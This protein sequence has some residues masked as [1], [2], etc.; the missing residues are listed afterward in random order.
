MSK[1]RFL[2]IAAA[3]LGSHLIGNSVGM[4]G[5][6]AFAAQPDLSCPCAGDA[7]DSVD[8][9]KI[10]RRGDS[11]R[12]KVV[13]S[14]ESEDEGNNTTYTGDISATD[15]LKVKK[16]GRASLMLRGPESES[17]FGAVTGIVGVLHVDGKNS[18]FLE[19][20]P[21]KTAADKPATLDAFKLR[22]R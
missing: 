1:Y 5:H 9:Y 17:I 18:F 6:R 4:L 21:E 7:C 16:G 2:I 3:L 19:S 12:V 22:C 11:L 13:V 10:S 14:S 8:L 20:S 15:Y